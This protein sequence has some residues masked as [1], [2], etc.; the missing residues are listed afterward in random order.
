MTETGVEILI[1][2][3]RVKTWCRNSVHYDKMK[4]IDYL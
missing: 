1:A 3:E 2:A 4:F